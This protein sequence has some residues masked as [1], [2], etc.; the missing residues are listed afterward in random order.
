MQF[1]TAEYHTA[2]NNNNNNNKEEEKD[3][4]K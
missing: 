1:K 2:A 3:K 4:V